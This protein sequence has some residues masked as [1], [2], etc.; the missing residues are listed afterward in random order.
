MIRKI[1][2]FGALAVLLAVA[3]LAAHAG[4]VVD[5]IV[6]TVNGHIILQSDWD[7]AVCYEAFMEGRPVEQ[8]TAAE[9]K[10]ALDRLIDQELL[11]EQMHAA[12]FHPAPDSDIGKRTLEIRKQYANAGTDPAWKTLLARYGLTQE[13]LKER[14]ALQ[15]NMMRLVDARLRPGIDIDAKSIESYYN[16]E[17]LPQLQQAGAKQVPLTDV[18]SEIKEILTQQKM[19]QL[20]TTWLQSLRAGS[21]IRTMFAPASAG[22]QTR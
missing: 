7:D 12:D 10:T 22:D 21:D 20:L 1:F 3:S 15:L 17:L 19:N 14:V 18:T 4:E 16:Q 11:R 5:R 2:S 9:R 8:S 13:G 6:A